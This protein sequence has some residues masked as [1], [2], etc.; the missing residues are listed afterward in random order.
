[1]PA[2]DP[3]F[4]KIM[5]ALNDRKFNPVMWAME[6]HG[7]ADNAEFQ[8]FLDMMMHL[9]QQAPY[10]AGQAQDSDRRMQMIQTLI[11]MGR[12]LDEGPAD[13]VR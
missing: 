7:Y 5:A 1:M 9:I 2:S 10:H 3:N 6:F 12:G 11:E 8:V 4:K 13:S